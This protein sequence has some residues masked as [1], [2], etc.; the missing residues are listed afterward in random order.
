MG[1][2]RFDRAARFETHHRAAEGREDEEGPSG[3]ECWH[4]APCTMHHAP[5]TRNS[6]HPPVH[7]EY[8][9]N[10]L[11]E[12][13]LGMEQEPYRGFDIGADEFADNPDPRVPCVLLLD[14]SGSMAGRPIDELNAGLQQLRDELIQDAIASRRV[15]LAIHTFGGHV[16][17]ERDFTSARAFVP[18]L[19]SPS[20]AT[21]MAEAIMRGIQHLE[22]RKQTYQ[23][24]GIAWYR[25][26]V[27]LI[28]DGASTDEPTAWRLA[29]DAVA[30][31][32]EQKKFVFFAI[33]TAEADF[34]KLR[35]ASGGR[36]PLRLK[37]IA[38]RE[39]FRWLSNSLTRVSQSQIG[40]ALV[41]PPATGSDGWGEIPT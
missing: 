8:D 33:G 23:S 25:P 16:Q 18:P 22:G 29:C 31:G 17:M 24:R 32:E 30:L 5:R 20:G 12:W 39:L 7:I 14:T 10:P 15:E 19:L 36:Q 1:N 13:R 41:L 35:E 40:T 2:G 3:G 37:G 6:N 4:L 28:T 9:A 11:S 34:V 27:F 38:F 21:P 26:W